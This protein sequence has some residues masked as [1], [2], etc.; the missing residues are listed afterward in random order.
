MRARV[1]PSRRTRHPGPP[2][3]YRGSQRRVRLVKI[4]GSQTWELWV[5]IAWVLFLL[6]SVIPAL[7]RNSR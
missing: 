2:K 5:L 4:R 1:T 7:I 6:L 3:V